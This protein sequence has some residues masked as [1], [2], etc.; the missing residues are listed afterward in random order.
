[1]AAGKPTKVAFGLH[2]LT[3]NYPEYHDEKWPPWSEKLA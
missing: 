1:M 2:A 3:V